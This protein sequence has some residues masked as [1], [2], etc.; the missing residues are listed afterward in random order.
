MH[1]VFMYGSNLHPLRLQSRAPSWDGNYTRAFLSDREL[2]FNKRS[3][4]YIVAANIIPHPTRRVWGI[5]VNL[6][7]DDLQA[8]D[9][10]EGCPT[11]YNRIWASP[12][13]EGGE[14]VKTHTYQAHPDT[15]LEGKHPTPNYLQYVLE[16]ARLCG[17]PE[18]YI[19]AIARSGRAKS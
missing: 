12:C 7:S 11:N 6:N 18:D 19:N 13:L 10:Y 1:P 14:I 16:G 8:M 3:R 9:G 15:I 2:R 5:I 17:L 4:K